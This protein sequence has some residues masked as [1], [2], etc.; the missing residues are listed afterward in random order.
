MPTLRPLALTL[1]LL[2]V[3]FRASGADA[4]TIGTTQILKW[5]D[6][7]KAAFTLGFDDSAPSQL[8]HVVPE[9]ERRKIVG[10]GTLGTG[11]KH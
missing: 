4:P 6:G 3:G 10:T 5:K 7:K 1:T 11:N 9:L 2:A 8:A